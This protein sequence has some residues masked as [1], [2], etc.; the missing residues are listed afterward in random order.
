M[1]G[2]YE[3][4]EYIRRL[5]IAKLTGTAIGPV[6]K[7]ILSSRFFFPSLWSRI[8]PSRRV[9]EFGYLPAVLAKRIFDATL[10]ETRRRDLWRRIGPLFRRF[11]GL[12]VANKTLILLRVSIEA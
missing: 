5:Q 12:A 3:L 1:S 4:R 6:N 8:F 10:G 2:A 11:L 9:V 7:E